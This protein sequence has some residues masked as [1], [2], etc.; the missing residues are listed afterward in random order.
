MRFLERVYKLAQKKDATI[1]LAEAEDVRILKAARV[2]EQKNLAKLILIGDKQKISR[3]LKRL[4]IT[5]R[6]GIIDYASYEK[7]D[8]LAK[9]LA[10]LRRKKGMTL[11]EAKR[12][13]KKDTKYFAAML[14]K[15]RMADGFVA[16]N[17]CPTRDTILPA[18]EII[19]SKGFASSLFFMLFKG[20]PLIF[21]DCG[22]NIAPT[23][24]QL[25]DIGV[26]SAKSAARFDLKPKVAFLSFS[27]HG[28]ASHPR[29]DV[30]RKAAL[31]AKRRLRGI[32]VDGEMQF[33][34]AFVPRVA[35]IKCPDSPL[36]GKANVFIFPDLESGNIAYKIGEYMGGEQA[37]GPIIQGLKKPVNDLSRGCNPED[38]VDVVA[39]TAA[40]TK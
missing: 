8:W 24:E 34:A 13:L 37:I 40:E 11:P 32:P 10:L 5:L 39:I 20:T 17:Q 7:A 27:T 1:I 35:K 3:L 16:G 36:K 26:S 30:V 15:T 22:F 4:K 25:A 21:A 12:L 38:I 28:S 29:V 2:I 6:A 33:D 14:V 18:L 31:L 9:E 23:A 19:G